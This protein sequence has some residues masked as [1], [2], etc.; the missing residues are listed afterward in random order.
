MNYAEIPNNM[1]QSNTE[2]ENRE[3][4]ADYIHH[5]HHGMVEKE[6]ELEQEVNNQN[7]HTHIQT[8]THPKQMSDVWIYLAKNVFLW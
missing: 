1:L 6:Q 4:I 2:H 8:Y 3:L 7:V 5:H